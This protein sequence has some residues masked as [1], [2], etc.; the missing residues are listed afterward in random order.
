MTLPTPALQQSRSQRADP[1]PLREVAHSGSRFAQPGLW[2]AAC[3]VLLATLAAAPTSAQ[4]DAVERLVVADAARWVR[5][6]D[7]IVRGEAALVLAGAAN[8]RYHAAIVQVARD[9]EPEAR[10]RG[11]LAL[12]LQASPGVVTVLDELLERQGDRTETAG[13]CAAWALGALP[14]DR[15]PAETARVLTSFVD[16]NWKRQGRTLL[17][18]LAGMSRHEQPDLVTALRQLY[19]VRSNRDPVIRAHLLGLLLPFELADEKRALEL[20]HRADWRE[21]RIV[22]EWLAINPTPFDAELIAPVERI[23]SGGARPELRA[24]ALAVLTRL[25]HPPAIELAA[26]ALR[27]R[28]PVEAQ[29]G[30]HSALAIGGASMRLAL[31]RHLR[32][33]ATPELAAAML[34]AWAAPPTT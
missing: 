9:P 4:D 17:A 23:A 27:S 28:F 1:A 15:A 18:L 3:A 11:L 32:D 10:L 25:R 34:E 30:M 24:A 5:H 2:R 8:P 16:G 13:L 31:D 22:L 14:P 21:R 7:P 12:G 33:T 19:A 26:K 6:A 20:L 29:Q